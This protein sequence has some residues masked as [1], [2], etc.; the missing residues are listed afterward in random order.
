MSLQAAIAARSL[1]YSQRVAQSHAEGS[2]NS[3]VRITRGGGWNPATYEYDEAFD[4]VIYDNPDP[5]LA[6][7][8][9]IAGISTESGSVQSDYAD[10]PSYTSSTTIYVPQT[11]AITPRI[12]DLVEVLAC[13]DPETEGQIMRV[14][15]VT[16]GGRISSSIS[17]SVTT[18]PPS[19]EVL[20]A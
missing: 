16:Y 15:D 6:G 11:M 20:P 10:E 9:W 13:P 1:A 2:M 3:L 8:G 18:S 5:D 17:L 4:E 14:I 12:D 19:K 7:T